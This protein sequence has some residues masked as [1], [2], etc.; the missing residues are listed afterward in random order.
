VCPDAQAL[1]V[2]INM[3][4]AYNTAARWNVTVRRGLSDAAATPIRRRQRIN[5]P[6]YLIIC[7]LIAEKP[8]YCAPDST[9]KSAALRSFYRI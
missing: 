1:R 5:P 6:F 7:A 3:E 9:V 2:I 8:V 4:T